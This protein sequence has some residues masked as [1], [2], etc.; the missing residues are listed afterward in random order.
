VR[1]NPLAVLL[2]EHGV[3]LILLPV[4]WVCFAIGAERIDRGFFSQRVALAMAVCIAAVV[5]L[6]FVY[7]AVRPYT[8]PLLFYV[9]PPEGA[10]L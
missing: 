7:A 3:W 5:T 2:R 8:R 1:W 9:R 10:K 6:L 4:F